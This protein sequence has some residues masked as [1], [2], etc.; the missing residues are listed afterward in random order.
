MPKTATTDTDQPTEEPDYR[1]A[2][3]E[4]NDSWAWTDGFARFISDRVEGESLKVCTGVRPICDVNVD[5]DVDGTQAD[6]YGD[7]FDLPF[8]ANA[9]DTVVC[10]PPWRDLSTEDRA[11]LIS[12]LVRVCRPEGKV[13]FNAPWILDHEAVSNTDFRVRQEDDFA[14]NNS[15]VTFGEKYSVV[16]LYGTADHDA[17]PDDSATGDSRHQEQVFWNNVRS[18]GHTVRDDPESVDADPRVMD[19][20][21]EQYSC[22]QCNNSDLEYV[23][24]VDGL[25]GPVDYSCP[26]C[27]FRMPKSEVV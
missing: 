19:P 2:S 26:A 16:E 1:R 5:I 25:P 13:I 24:D 27:Q 14:G 11:D 6:Q 9:F 8:T 20:S 15:V 22:A 7:M 3:H 21:Y 17:F 12:E 4:Y 23:G 18:I 10:D